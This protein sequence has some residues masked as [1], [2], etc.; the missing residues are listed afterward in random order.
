[1][2]KTIILA[3]S[4]VFLLLAGALSARAQAPDELQAFQDAAGGQSILF[5][6]KQAAR[7]NFPANGNP[8]WEKADFQRGDILFE[9]NLYRNVLLNIDAL[10]QR[11]LVHVESG[12]FA[13]ALPPAL[14]QTLTINGRRFEG[15]GPGEGL[16]EGFYEVLGQGPERVYKNVTKV[17]NSTVGDHNGDTIGYY[18]NNYRSDVMR[19]FAIQRNYYFRDREGYFSRIRNRRALIR[20]FPERQKEIRRAV[21]DILASSPDSDFDSVYEVI[22]YTASR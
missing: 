20:K 3:L 7:Y 11:A 13:V 5:R 2:K 21:R 14:T 9:G 22:L 15:I 6:G 10:A 17:L 16:P 12:P 19:H 1:M 8:Y 4:S 18:D